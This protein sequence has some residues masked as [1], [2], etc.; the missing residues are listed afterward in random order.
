MMMERQS[1]VRLV[2]ILA[3]LVLIIWLAPHVIPVIIGLLVRQ[4]VDVNVVL[5]TIM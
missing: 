4:L 1:N 2:I 3:K 5:S